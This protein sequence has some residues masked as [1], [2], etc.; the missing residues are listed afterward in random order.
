M[1]FRVIQIIRDTFGDTFWLTKC[2]LSILY[3]LKAFLMPLEVNIM[4]E[5]KVRHLKDTLFLSTTLIVTT[6]AI[7]SLITDILKQNVTL[8][9]GGQGRGCQKSVTYYLNGSICVEA[10]N[11][12]DFCFFISLS[13]TCRV[14]SYQIYLSLS[15]S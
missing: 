12:H 7:K 3:L 8:W 9:G 6:N 5:G 11:L 4:L 14:A 13:T 1:C 10:I 15:L 2:H